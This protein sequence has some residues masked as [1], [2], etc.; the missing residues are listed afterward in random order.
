M[1]TFRTGFTCRPGVIA[2]ALSLLFAGS[3]MAHAQSTSDSS[4]RGITPRSEAPSS[5][6][7]SGGGEAKPNAATGYT[8]NASAP[9]TPGA[10][11]GDPASTGVPAATGSKSGSS[12]ISGGGSIGSGGS[13]GGSP[14][15][16]A[17]SKDGGSG[18]S[19]AGGDAKS[20]TL[21]SASVPLSSDDLQLMRDM[22]RANMAEIET[23]SL[24]QQRTQNPKV[25]ELAQKIA[26]DHG[27]MQE[28]MKKIARAKDVPLP[29]ETGEKH[30]TIVKRLGS[31][32][33]EAFDREY[34]AATGLEEKQ[35]TRV[36]LQKI[37]KEASDNELKGLASK[38]LPMVEQH[39]QTAKNMQGAGGA[40][41]VGSS[42][43]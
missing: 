9:N 1:L 26:T 25:R 29:V 21:N 33:G 38:M 15:T 6:S 36:L 43:K 42:G 12:G 32:S 40:T 35:N 18:A 11:G 23:A 20:G 39:L 27:R 41:S 37:S 14:S 19:G 24:A 10:M 2:V 4:P 30:T 7:L 8:G 28:E 34:T 13:T 31:L 22:A 16:G 17:N 3:S 5:P